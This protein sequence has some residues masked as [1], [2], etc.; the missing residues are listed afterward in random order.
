MKTIHKL[1]TLLLVCL[2]AL[3]A[4]GLSADVVETKNGAR[5][6]G[7]VVKFDDGKIIVKT[8]YAGELAI[9]QSE[10]TGVT[11]DA[12]IVV[13]L[14]SGTT[15][16]GKLTSSGNDLRIDGAD[17]QLTT[18]VD[19]VAAS[20]GTGEQDPQVLALTRHWKYEAAVDIVGKTGN[21]EQLGTTLAFRATMK[22]PQDTL[23]VY[24]G[25]D[26]QVTNGTKSSDQFKAGIDYQNNFAGR[27]SWYMRDE[28][29]FDRV[30]D[31][32]L[33]N[34][35]AAG[36]GYDFI[37]EPKRILT[38]RAGLSFRYEDYGN[39]AHADLKSMGLDLGLN[40]EWELANSKIVNR[41]SYVP[42]F[43]DFSNYRFTHESYYEIPLT[44]PAW[45]L[46]MGV[47]N[48]YTSKPGPGV[49]SLD[50]SYFTRFVLNWD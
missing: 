43:D 10:V 22:T 13:R 17:G 12:P 15:L 1:R 36:F 29:G 38:G 37:K 8:D 45:K 4:V 33:Y 39:P 25:Y 5:I 20:W 3:F 7:K 34:T 18:T 44:N 16:A 27:L 19:K 46:R 2:P 41:I 30:K 50:T 35:A 26:R 6:V 24:T 21:S 11:T 31:I 47:S 40:H 14:S 32:N 48:D 49:E 9:K 28:G 42:S 23:Q